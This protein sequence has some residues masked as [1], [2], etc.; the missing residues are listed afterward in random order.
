MAIFPAP[1]VMQLSLGRHE[2]ERAP[3]EDWLSPD[4][5]QGQIQGPWQP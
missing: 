2:L 3:G 5:H 1:T 4:H